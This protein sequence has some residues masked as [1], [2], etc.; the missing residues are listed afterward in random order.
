M[1]VS[2][3]LRADPIG[4]RGKPILIEAARTA[5]YAVLTDFAAARITS[6]TTLG[7]DSMGT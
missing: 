3:V 1:I 5:T 7:W 6:S 2:M 4:T